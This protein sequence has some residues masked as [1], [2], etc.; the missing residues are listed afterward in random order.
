MHIITCFH[1]QKIRRALAID[2]KDHTHP[3]GFFKLGNWKSSQIARFNQN[4]LDKGRIDLLNKIPYWT[5]N[6]LQ[7]KF[8]MNIKYSEDILCELQKS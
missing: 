6:P 7:E 2:N 5:F 4:K 1:L 8:L 3:D